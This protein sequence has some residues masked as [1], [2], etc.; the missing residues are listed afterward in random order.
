ML[1][2]CLVSFIWDFGLD[3]GLRLL[4]VVISLLRC[5][6]CWLM[7]LNV[8]W[9][10]L[11]VFV[12]TYLVGCFEYYF[13]VDGCLDF[14]FCLVLLDYWIMHDTC[15]WL[16]WLC[17]L[18]LVFLLFVFCWVC[19]GRCFV[20]LDAF[21]FTL[22]FVGFASLILFN[23]AY[24]VVLIVSIVWVYWF[25]V[26]LTYFVG[27]WRVCVWLRIAEL[28]FAYYVCFN[29]VYFCDMFILFRYFVG[30]VW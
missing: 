26:L 14:C 3:F 29:L 9:W 1:D 27:C 12:I 18:T 22:C 5:C 2:W 23:V 15:A 8:V 28:N 21:E 17:W 7:A 30:L 19:C 16:L 25:W 4:D 6:V 24:L 11:W 20:S 10:L 13:G